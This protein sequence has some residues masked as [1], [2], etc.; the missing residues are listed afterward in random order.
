V[1]EDVKRYTID[2]KKR[3]V[4]L[5]KIGTPIERYPAVFAHL[6]RYQEQLEKRWDK[7][8]HW[9][10]L[11]ACDYYEEFEK[12]KIMFPDI[13]KRCQFAYDIDGYF[14]GNT[15]YFMSAGDDQKF[16][17]ALLNSSLIEFFFQTISA[18]IRGDYLRFFTQYVTQIPIRRI[19]YTTPDEER[20][21][22]VTR[23]TTYYESG[24]REDLLALVEACLAS[25]PEQSDV[26]HDLLVYLAEQMIDLH[27]QRAQALENLLLALESVLSDADLQR[28]GR[29][30]TPPAARKAALFEENE[31]DPRATEAQEKLGALA[32]RQLDLRDDIGSLNEEQWKWL[33]KRRLN[34]P[35]LV[36]LTKVFRS[37]QP[38]IAS[39][40]KR[41]SSSDRLIDQVVY[42]LYGLT[43]EEVATVEARTK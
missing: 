12:P 8:N 20:A 28:L 31:P 18:F 9:W 42:R 38:A 14:S 40:D 2:Y 21:A 43:E 29:L 35:D 7:G 39:L 6:Q 10:E 3:H 36:E 17:L 24:R 5:T 33:V 22:L 4:I 16:M 23:G 26:V 32:T 13:A 34:R 30:W 41:I 37:R 15:T 27:R 1:G 25:E 19:A 11:R